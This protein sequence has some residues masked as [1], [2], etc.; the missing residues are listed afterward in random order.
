MIPALAKT[1]PISKN[2]PAQETTKE[3]SQVYIEGKFYN[4][5]FNKEL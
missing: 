5:I 1:P 4:V 3:P 2:L